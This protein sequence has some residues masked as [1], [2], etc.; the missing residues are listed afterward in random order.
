MRDPCFDR[1]TYVLDAWLED[2]FVCMSLRNTHLIPF[3]GIILSFYIRLLWAQQVQVS[4][5]VRSCFVLFFIL[6]EIFANIIQ[7][8]ALVGNCSFSRASI[9]SPRPTP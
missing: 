9:C 3:Y 4:C 7:H 2:R 5:F 8:N 1:A 6:N